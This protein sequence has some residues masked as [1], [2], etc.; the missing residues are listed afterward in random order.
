[1]LLTALAAIPV[2]I[3]I[4]LLLARGC[5]W[6]ISKSLER[7][8]NSEPRTKRVVA[9]IPARNEAEV[10][11]EAV[12][13]LLS[14]DFPTPLEIVVV[15]DASTDATAAIAKSAA[16]RGGAPERLTVIRAKPL[17]PGWT[18]K[19]WAL[20]QGVAA[21]MARAPDYLLLT[22]A[23]IRHGKRS[24]AE[25]IAVAESRGC[26]LAS[27]MVKLKCETWAEKALIPAFVFFF[28]MLYPPAWIASDRKR[29]AGAAGGCILIR[30]EAL[31]RIGGL[32]SIRSEIID[33][34]ALARAV[35]RSGGKIWM[36]LSASTESI[37]SYGSFA[38]IGRMISRT[39]F[40]QLH[41]SASILAGTMIGL[42]VTYLLP[43]VLLLSGKR[44]PIAFG[45][46]ACFLMAASYLPM[47]RFYK[48]SLLWSFSLPA[49]A[50]FYMGATL[51]SAF[52]YWSGKGG[53]WKDRIQDA[54]AS[55][56]G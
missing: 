55:G 17:I 8:S 14:Q 30:P 54:R 5:F 33:D 51:H 50:L 36:G 1:V 46:V 38:E 4:Y 27:L 15:D 56:M 21:A 6:R 2:L 22:D 34:C 16:K 19:L 39:A 35:K 52:C 12:A 23:D 42:F 37:R 13:S 49:I 20:S 24:V 9:V 53:K 28:L 18:G 48:R 31:R 47:V 26:D 45:A 3:W 40:N 41:H 44:L 10:I 7:S 43:P 29:T 25:L 11:G 32:A